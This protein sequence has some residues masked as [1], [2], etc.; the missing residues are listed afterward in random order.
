MIIKH[1]RLTRQPEQKFIWANVNAKAEIESIPE[2]QRTGRCARREHKS[3]VRTKRQP[4]MQRARAA[5]AR[6]RL[7]RS[8]R[9][10]R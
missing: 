9:T 1:S 5:H 2:A 3:A 7:A 8:R 10:S 6:A 4:Q